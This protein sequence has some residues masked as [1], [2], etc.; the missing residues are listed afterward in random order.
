MAKAAGV[1][2]YGV[3]WGFHTEAEIRSGGADDM[4]STMADLSSGLKSFARALAA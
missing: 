3:D 1:S 4:F 2:A